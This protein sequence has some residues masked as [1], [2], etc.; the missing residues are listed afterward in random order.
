M[1]LRTVIY[2]VVA[3]LL[4]TTPLYAQTEAKPVATPSSLSETYEDWSVNCAVQESGTRRCAL[5][6]QQMHKGGQ[7]VL[8][9]EFVPDGD[10]GLKG[11][12]AMPF[13]LYL[14]KGVTFRIDDNPA[15][16]PSRF[17]TCMSTGC[18]VP[19]TFTDATTKVLRKGKAL[20][21]G[22]FASDTEKD[23]TFSIS[24]KGFE[25]A[26]NRTIELLR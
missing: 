5:S 26:L 24:L 1:R 25:P 23:V 12:L 10:T 15:G 4:A 13:G 8:T 6:Q 2:G 22:A 11:N 17:R 9:I 21:L 14:E 19:L 3:S 16:K 18:I 20:N 7:R